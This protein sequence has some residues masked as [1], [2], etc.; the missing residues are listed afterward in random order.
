MSSKRRN[1]ILL[2][3]KKRQKYLKALDFYDGTIDGIIGDKTKK[4]YKELQKAYFTRKADIDG[5]YGKD[6]DTL[7]RNAYIV[8]KYCKNF[9]LKEFKC[10]CGGKYCTGYPTV[11]DIQ[12]LKNLQ[13]VREKFG[14]TIITS[15]LR[16]TKHNEAVGGVSGSR[17]RTGKAVDIINSVSKTEN[18]RKKIMD[19]WGT[20]PK[21]RYTYCNIN[22][23]YPNMGT[24]VHIDVK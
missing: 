11:I 4:A 5:L 10:Q 15:A 9:E 23:D 7:L 1:N 16:C 17:H 3:K 22:G 21:Q 12:L 20:L 24:A 18:G 2:S 6:T 8:K 13:A 14:S 19:F